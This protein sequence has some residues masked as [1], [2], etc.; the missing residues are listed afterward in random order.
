MTYIND[1]ARRSADIHWPD[2]HDPAE[3][4]LF[5]HNEITIECPVETIWQHL[6]AAVAWPQW[7]SNARNVVVNDPSGQLGDGV[8]FGWST[9]GLQITSTVAEFVPGER[10]GWYGQGEGLSAYHSWLLRPRDRSTYVVMEEGGL[11]P[12][13]KTL[14]QFNPGQLHRGHDLWNISLKFR[15]ES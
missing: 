2:G 14:A 10:L 13:A 11:G 12:G 4:D 15:C 6:V 1:F 8:T 9:F 7:Y 5:A 3:A